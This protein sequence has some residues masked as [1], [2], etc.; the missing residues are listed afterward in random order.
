MLKGYNNTVLDKKKLINIK[1]I[2]KKTGI[3]LRFVQMIT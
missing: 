2:N 3:D 1:K